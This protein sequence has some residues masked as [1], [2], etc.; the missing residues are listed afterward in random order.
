M[1][2]S[3]VLVPLFAFIALLGAC[4]EI[5]EKHWTAALPYYTPVVISSPADTSPTDFLFGDVMDVLD[6]MTPASREK[7]TTAAYLCNQRGPPTPGSGHPSS[8]S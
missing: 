4:N 8:Y 3:F 5:P 2:R 7:N 1:N 6:P